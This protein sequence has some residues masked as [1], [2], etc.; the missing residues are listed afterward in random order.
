MQHHA[1]YALQDKLYE[2]Y[3][4][5][6]TRYLHRPTH[7]NWHQKELLLEAY[8]RALNTKNN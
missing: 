4:K 8:Q 1:Q 6:Q 2:A 3:L 5:A 7:H